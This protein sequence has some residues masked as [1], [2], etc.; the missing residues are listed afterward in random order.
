MYTVHQAKTNLSKLIRK[1]GNG[2]EVIIAR[3]KTPVAKLVSLS[4]PQNKRIPGRLK[5][6]IWYAADAFEPMSVRKRTQGVITP[7][8]ERRRLLAARLSRAIGSHRRRMERSYCRTAGTN[9]SAGSQASRRA[10][11]ERKTPGRFNP[12]GGAHPGSRRSWPVRATLLSASA[13]TA[14]PGRSRAMLLR[15]TFQASCRS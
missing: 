8:P 4:S 9:G 12:A 5:G 6:K 15:Q 7:S 11:R 10:L 2:E 3:G 13:S 14:W 1:A